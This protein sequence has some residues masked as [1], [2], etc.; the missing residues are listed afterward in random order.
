MRPDDIPVL[1]ILRQ[2]LGYHSDRQR[3]IAENV[4]NANTPGYVPDDIPQ[5]E[6]AR[7][8]SGAQSTSRVTL[9]ASEAG[10]I[11]GRVSSTGSGAWRAVA[12]PDSETTIN[13]N[14]VVLEEQMVRSGENRMRFETAL[15][16]YQKSLSLIR[17]AARAPGS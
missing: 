17:M 7:A 1:G 15:G 12:A 14:A 2:A 16:L 9:N 3:V 4:A 6:F 13:G 11:Q 10:H 8:L 5:S